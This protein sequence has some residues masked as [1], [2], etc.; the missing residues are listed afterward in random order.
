MSSFEVKMHMA[1]QTS[2]STEHTLQ[3]SWDGFEENSLGQS[4]AISFASEETF[5]VALPEFENAGRSVYG[6]FLQP[7]ESPSRPDPIHGDDAALES[8]LTD[9]PDDTVAG[10]AVTFTACDTAKVD[11]SP[12]VHERSEPPKTMVP[13]DG[14]QLES[15]YSETAD[16]SALSIDSGVFDGLSFPCVDEYDAGD[17]VSL[18]LGNFLFDKHHRPTPA[19][20]DA[21]KKPRDRRAVVNWYKM[22]NHLIDFKN[23]NGNCN[24]PQKL[25]VEL[26]GSVAKLG[27]W[28]VHSS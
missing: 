1:V 12:R 19:E 8:I 3:R 13:E 6:N 20:L 2:K 26:E 27:Y 24:V 14:C 5:E 15:A 23:V 21:A 28:C 9:K 10:M 18:D 7:Q 17:E 25:Q 4:V 22:L 16:E 11:P